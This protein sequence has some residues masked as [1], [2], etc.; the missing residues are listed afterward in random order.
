MRAVT[1]VQLGPML[2]SSD[3]A[4]D[5]AAGSS[6]QLVSRHGSSMMGPRYGGPFA[7]HPRR[8]M[9]HAC[10]HCPLLS[11]GYSGEEFS[12]NRFMQILR[13]SN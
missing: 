2:R 5:A 4:A 8:A 3:E 1:K 9:H 6:A 10:M 12:E 11:F 13:A 7:H